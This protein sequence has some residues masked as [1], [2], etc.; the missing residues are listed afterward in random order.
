VTFPARIRYVDGT[1]VLAVTEIYSWLREDIPAPIM[2]SSSGPKGYTKNDVFAIF[3]A[4]PSIE[5]VVM[6]RGHGPTFFLLNAGDVWTDITGR[7]VVQEP[8]LKGE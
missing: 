3:N 6:V 5:R 1:T 7:Q 8:N 4:D 2:S